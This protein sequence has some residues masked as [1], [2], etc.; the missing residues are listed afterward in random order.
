[1]KLKYRLLLSGFIVALLLFPTIEFAAGQPDDSPEGE[2][3]FT[4]EEH[5]LAY[6]TVNR[7]FLF[8]DSPVVGKSCDFKSELKQSEDGSRVM[9][10][11]SVPV[12]SFDSKNEERDQELLEILKTDEFPDVHF[13]TGWLEAA[14]L[15]EALE[16]GSLEL[17]G[18][19]RIAGQDNRI[20]LPLGIQR[21]TGG[22][23]ITGNLITSLTKFNI[24]IPSVGPG[25]VI[26]STTDEFEIL[27]HLL[28]EQVV[29]AGEF[30]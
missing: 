21:Q 10:I 6:R 23:V 20:I 7:M 19:L 25:G 12:K 5:C 17:E 9:I 4:A 27:V 13:T 15:R 22:I 28:L 16:K 1:M 18:K 2:A 29:G 26:A 24:D 11:V 30:L 8:F 3:V 14:S